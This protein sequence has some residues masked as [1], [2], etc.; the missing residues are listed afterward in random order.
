LLIAGY[1]ILGQV[2]R[3]K[4]DT[5]L[6]Q[7]P[8]SLHVTY[9]R[10][11]VGLLSGSMVIHG[12]VVKFAPLADSQHF[13]RMSLDLVTV[14]G[15]RFWTLLSSKKLM[16]GRLAEEGGA[17]VLDHY[18][19]EKNVPIPKVELPF[20]KAMIDRLEMRDMRVDVHYPISGAGEVVHLRGFVLQK[21]RLTVDTLRVLPALDKL[22]MGRRKGYQLDCIEASSE[23]LVVEGLDVP[24]LLQKRLIADEISVRRNTIYVFR[25]RRLPLEP[26][27]KPMPA[28]WLRRLPVL[29]K[30]G[31]VKIGTTSFVY[32]EFPKKGDK[33]GVLKIVRLKGTIVPLINHPEKG[34]PAYL[35]M[36]MEGSLMGSGLVSATT[37]IPLREGAPYEVEGAFHELDVTSLNPSAEN[38]GNIHLESGTLNS[39]A[40]WFTMDAEQ[41][42]GKIVGEYHHLVADKLKGNGGEKKVDKLK[43]FFLKKLIIPK[44]KDRSLPEVKRTGKV[45]YKRDP[46]RYFSYYLLHSLLV[47]VKSSFSL[48]FLLPG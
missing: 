27:N 1:F 39:L 43:S 47:G 7:L 21:N 45:D 23:G 29:V 42:T 30:V 37:R 40:F 20:T 16:V 38:L 35:T 33:T 3:R 12:L 22:E 24:A 2:V 10:L 6:Q 31:K 36:K 28:E 25:D 44:D 5:V 9:V 15:I 34:D 11:D 13:H 4:V 46:S 17:A 41:A 14:Q 18:L 19:L 8:P 48:G 26:G 32:E